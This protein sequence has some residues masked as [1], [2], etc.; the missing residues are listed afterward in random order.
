MF[1]NCFY[2]PIKNIL[3]PSASIWVFK[4]WTEYFLKYSVMAN[5]PKI[6]HGKQKDC[7]NEFKISSEDFKDLKYKE[8]LAENERLKEIIRNSNIQT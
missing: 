4:F 7:S 3:K 8:A 1:A 6:W 5:N 2:E